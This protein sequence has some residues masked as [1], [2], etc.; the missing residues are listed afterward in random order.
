MYIKSD[1]DTLLRMIVTY[2]G[3]ESAI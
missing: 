1:I 3:C 2:T